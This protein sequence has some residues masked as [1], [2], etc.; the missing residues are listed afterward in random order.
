MSKGIIFIFFVVALISGCDS[1]N[2][3]VVNFTSVKKAIKNCS[4]PE[5]PYGDGGGHDAGFDWAEDTGSSCSG[6]SQSFIDGCEEYY[7]QLD[8][9]ERCKS[10]N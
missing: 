2:E 3:E 10:G 4:E 7:R 5:N 8:T 9:Y 1:K 6:N